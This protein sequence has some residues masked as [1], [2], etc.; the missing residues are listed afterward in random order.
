[1]R[2][3]F[4]SSVLSILLAAV[5]ATS[6][7]GD[8]DGDGGAIDAATVAD[9]SGTIDAAPPD[10]GID[11]VARGEYLVD[12]IL[13]CGDCHTPRLETGA[14]DVDNYL[15]GN[16]CFIDLSPPADNGE[17]C[18]PTPN[19]TD[20]ATGLANRTDEQIQTMF[21]DGVRPNDEALIPVMPYYQFHNL[22]TQDADAVV[23]YLRTVPGVDHAVPNPETGWQRPPAAVPNIDMTDVPEPA[24]TEDPDYDSAVRGRY[25]AAISCLECHTPHQMVAE[26]PP[27]V[28][29]DAFA[30]GEEFPLPPGFTVDAVI[31]PNI[32]PHANGI[33]GWTAE[34]ITTVLQMGTDPDEGPICPPMPAGPMA[35]FGGL[36]SEDATDIAH[37]LLSIP[38]DD[39]DP[40]IVEECAPAL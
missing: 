30:G 16:D 32:T 21:L 6:A 11:L 37:Y 14:P 4:D 10:A 7:C 29:D 23:A 24:D 20:H 8:D 39:N 25:L 3:C 33:S 40:G 38:A 28:M 12:H 26:E 2:A 9:A 17:G 5:L 15:A 13:V 34:D 22:T 27:V 19:L 35:A 1:M 36:T 18:L 31:S